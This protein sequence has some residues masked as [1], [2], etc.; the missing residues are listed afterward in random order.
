MSK[1]FIVF[2]G[3]QAEVSVQVPRAEELTFYKIWC[4]KDIL[5]YFDIWIMMKLIKLEQTLQVPS[6][7]TMLLSS[8]V[9]KN[10]VISFKRWASAVSTCL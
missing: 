6:V 5:L 2:A 3:D 8:F 7:G 10:T 9:A 1:V 4:K